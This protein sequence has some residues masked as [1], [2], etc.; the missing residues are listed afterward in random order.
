V[1]VISKFFDLV[2]IFW[3]AQIV[4][5]WILS[6]FEVYN[7]RIVLLFTLFLISIYLYIVYKK[8]A[9]VTQY[10]QSVISKF[11]GLN[12]FHKVMCVSTIL[13]WISVVLYSLIFIFISPAVNWDSLTYHLTKAAEANQTGTWWYHP[14][15]SVSRVNIFGSNTSILNAVAFSIFGKDYIVELPQLIAATIIPI[16]LFYIGVEFFKKRKLYSFVATVS[17][18]TIPLYFYETKTTQNDLLFT[19]IFLL[20]IILVFQL[21][22]TFNI[23]NL[24]LSCL[25]LGILTGTKYHGI[26]AAGV[27]A[28][29]VL[30]ILYRNKKFI[31]RK[32]IIALMTLLP[33]LVV[34]ALPSNIIGRLY[35]DS[36]F[37]LTSGDAKKVNIGIQTLWLNI[38][39]FSEWFYLRTIGDIYYFSFDYGHAGFLNMVAIPVFIVYSIFISIKK[40][41]EQILFVSSI[42]GLLFL[43][44]IVRSP[45]EW[46]LRLILFLPITAVFILVLYSI[47][48]KNKIVKLISLLVILILSI[49]NI[50]VTIYYVDKDVIKYSLS[51]IRDNRGIMT[52][53]NYY[54]SKE[55]TNIQ[56]FEEDSISKISDILIVGNGDSPLYP[57]YGSSWQN[58]VNH[59]RLDQINNDYLENVRWDYLIIYHNSSKGVL[60]TLD[61]LDLNYQILTSDFYVN[62][63][64]NETIN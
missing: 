31:D 18:L 16:A 47:S 53:G 17:V 43:L 29:F 60:S 46:D 32:Y 61:T 22:K 52:I 26:I 4:F 21:S 58:T 34:L 50:L 13:I 8:T 12:N 28:L 11:R 20:S 63:Y 7:A 33:I 2:V 3:S 15:I 14:D 51:S 10:C 37:A 49:S 25:S 9:I 64:A 23:R 62:I 48:V 59:I 24:V 54:Y 44:F 1:K 27:L 57:Y 19:L 36:F 30:Y 45:D 5:A 38:T 56:D 42:F 41:F 55:M 35:Y 6:A 40:S 39:H